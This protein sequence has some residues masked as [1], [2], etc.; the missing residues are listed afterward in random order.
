MNSPSTSKRLDFVLPDFTRVSWTDE[1][2]RA[3]W[4][5]RMRRIAQA[6]SVVEWASVAA[7]VRPCALLR[8]PLEEYIATAPRWA[9]AGLSPLPLRLEGRPDLPYV[10]SAPP[11]K[12]GQPTALRLVVGTLAHTLRFRAAW[13]PQ[14]PEEIGKLLGYPPCCREAF[15]QRWVAKRSLDPTWDMAAATP[16]ALRSANL[17]ETA[18]EPL[19]NVLWRWMGVRAAPHLPCTFNCAPSRQFAEQM[20]DVGI[21]AGFAGEM[22][23]I[24]E[25]LSWPVEW[26]A[27]H[28][29]AEV[30]TPILK[31]ST[32]TD[33]TAEKYVVRWKGEAYP[34]EG[35]QGLAFP[36]RT[37]AHALL[38]DSPG[39]QRGLE[40]LI[41][42]KAP[43]PDWH[44][45]DNGFSSRYGMDAQH[46]PIV[47]LA[48]RELAGVSGNVLDL[49]CGN[50]ILLEKI[51]RDRD[52]L[53]PWGCDTRTGVLEHAAAILPRFA[54]NF[55]Q[56]NL[57]DPELWQSGRRYALAIL[58]VGRLEEARGPKAEALLASIA[59]H[60]DRLLLYQSRGWSKENLETLAE[61]SGLRVRDLA[62]GIAG[63]ADLG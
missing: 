33:A 51:C 57:F 34:A 25:I 29:I 4:Q 55:V 1:K 56:R 37:P 45:L 44:H 3:A 27:L 54:G 22:G 41:E 42:L 62:A 9:M 20:L 50:G 12:P 13:D 63:M 28:G 40:N 43:Q 2:A 52:G 49:G 11:S 39:F 61:R 36:Y 26:S 19:V 48:R 5:P 17:A 21:R 24:R 16:G 32:R 23:W 59:A 18:G 38:S 47:A 8:M 60:C 35:A 6:W 58:M 30:K 31:V 10:S 7:Q 53:I 14:N 15:R 46:E